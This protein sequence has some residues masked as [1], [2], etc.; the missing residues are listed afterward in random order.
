M[1]RCRH[2]S[3]YTGI[4]TDVTRRVQEHRDGALGARYLRGRTPLKLV[5]QWTVGDRS[6]ALRVE[7][8]IKRLGKAAKEQLLARPNGIDAFLRDL[9]PGALRAFADSS[10]GE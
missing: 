7:R 5:G 4:A 10:A 1:V 2:N 8:R 6:T 3:L 9:Q